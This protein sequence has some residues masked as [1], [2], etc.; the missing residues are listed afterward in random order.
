M[1]NYILNTCRITCGETHGTGVLIS[2]NMVMTATH[3]VSCC[4][5]API[6]VAL[7]S[8]P[9]C[10]QCTAHWASTVESPVAILTLDEDVAY[11]HMLFF[12]REFSAREKATA[13]GFPAALP[14][15]YNLDMR[16]NNVNFA[17]SC[18]AIDANITL[19]PLNKVPS[20]KGMSGS[21]LIVD[22]EVAGILLRER[23]AEANAYI[24]YALAGADFRQ[25]L[26]DNGFEPKVGSTSVFSKQ[27]PSQAIGRL[28]NECRLLH[29]ELNLKYSQ[30]LKK[31]ANLR[32]SGKSTD[33]WTQLK[34]AIEDVKGR[35]VSQEAKASYYYL[36]A[37]WSL[38]DDTGEADAYFQEACS[39]NS[40]L[41]TRIF[42]SAQAFK[43]GQPDEAFELLGEID[44]IEILNERVKLLYLSDKRVEAIAEY[45]SYP[46]FPQ[47]DFSWELLALCNMELSN[48]EEAHVFADKLIAQYPTS[49]SALFLKGQICWGQALSLHR[50]QITHNLF[51]LIDPTH[52]LP[53]T[54]QQNYLNQAYD[55]YVKTIVYAENSI[56]KDREWYL[57]NLISVSSILPGKDTLQWLRKL[58]LEFP[59]SSLAIIT[60]IVMGLDILSTQSDAFLAQCESGPLSFGFLHAKYLLLTKLRR[61]DEAK[62]LFSLYGE[63]IAEASNMPKAVFEL[64]LA[65]Q[66]KDW[67][68]ARTVAEQIED[69]IQQKRMF[70]AIDIKEAVHSKRDLKRNIFALAEETGSAI[71]YC[72]AYNYCRK[73]NDWYGCVKATRGWY[74]ADPDLAVLMYQAEALLYYHR[75]S[76]A[77]TLLEKI[78][79]SGY[80][81]KTLLRLKAKCLWGLSKRDEVIALLDS[82]QFEED[83]AELLLL[84]AQSCVEKGCNDAAI[85]CLKEYVDRGYQNMAVMR[86]LV[87][88]LKTENLSEA[89][90]YA[91]KTHDAYPDDKQVLVSTYHLGLLVGEGDLSDEWFALASGAKGNTPYLKSYTTEEVL[92]LIENSRKSADDRHQKYI[93]MHLPLSTTIDFLSNTTL[94]ENFYAQWENG[95]LGAAYIVSGTGVSNTVLAYGSPVILDYSACVTAIE[96]D[97]LTEVC[98][99]WECYI[100]PLLMPAIS[101]EIAELN[102]IQNS[103][104]KNAELHEAAVSTPGLNIFSIPSGAA[105]NQLDLQAIAAVEQSYCIVADDLLEDLKKN[106]PDGWNEHRIS[107]QEFI[108]YLKYLGISS[109]AAVDAIIPDYVKNNSPKGFLLDSEILT[110][111]YKND[112]LQLAIGT[113]SIAILE[114]QVSTAH[115]EVRRFHNQ[116]KAAV[117]LKSAIHSTLAELINSNALH[118]LPQPEQLKY[119]DRYPLT[120]LFEHGLRTTNNSSYSLWYDDK[121]LTYLS[122]FDNK[123]LSFSNILNSLYPQ[124]EVSLYRRIDKLFHCHIGN[125]VP[126][127]PYMKNRLFLCRYDTERAM[128]LESAALRNVRQTISA[129]LLPK[130]LSDEVIEQ[131]NSSERKQYLLYLRELVCS[132]LFD[133]W[134]SDAEQSQTLAMASWVMDNLGSLVYD[135]EDDD[136]SLQ[137]LQTWQVIIGTLLETDRRHAYYS[138]LNAYLE[139]SWN[140][141]PD[142]ESAIARSFVRCLFTTGNIDAVLAALNALNDGFTIQSF[143]HK[144]F[145][146]ELI[147]ENIEIPSSLHWEPRILDSGQTDEIDESL[148]EEVIK[149]NENAESAILEA[150]YR[151]PATAAH[152]VQYLENAAK[153][154]RA[155]A[156]YEFLCTLYWHVPSREK[157]IIKKLFSWGEY[158]SMYPDK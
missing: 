57:A 12:P 106:A 13:Y 81:G 1:E 60:R 27:E 44:S 70:L 104:V 123:I 64:E 36:A 118:I 109:D 108:G 128:L 53:N 21:A 111:L 5:T 147:K 62:E 121:Y 117:W 58:E 43:A 156:S 51:L 15:G 18:S 107:H 72:N 130:S 119:D 48:Y 97:I 150:V 131:I 151:S 3:V 40:S 20:Y 100:S 137:Y 99:R 132:L 35:S 89:F 102:S 148:V 49:P 93:N 95:V 125:Y 90:A 17:S 2:P 32:V 92:K 22:G 124:D 126:E 9:D 140:A 56:P 45:Q 135:G 146:H 98:S 67:H 83:D 80:S 75:E 37:V 38:E 4:D 112:I 127:M 16:I 113:I 54:E 34:S 129:T 149:R 101:R 6:I 19:D 74:R 28:T 71:D 24:V 144:V 105:Q 138:W 25:A 31:L 55:Y 10:K 103:Q 14:S 42:C 120:M 145:S 115:N 7:E 82:I 85:R 33:A 134:S 84:K 152:L 46:G 11:Q 136:F 96:L 65:L 116:M 69:T 141:S 30:E 143:L 139:P 63:K 88:F 23:V 86:A 78:E 26:R 59:L 122:Y 29:S 154:R 91:K 47:N 8:A 142:D 114:E 76:R 61:I 155:N 66:S 110:A 133:I 153:L 79:E 87:S 68:G 94:G 73:Q 41:D 50:P 157:L 52:F 77:L 158:W 39:I